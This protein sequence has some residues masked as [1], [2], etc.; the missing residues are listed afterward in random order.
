M[1]IPL[2]HHNTTIFPSPTAFDPN[3][4]INDPKLDRYLFSFSRGPRACIGINLAWAELYNVL[5]S[6]FGHYGDEKGQG[7]SMK[8]WK[9]TI[10]D[11]TTKHDLFVPFPFMESEGVR[12]VLSS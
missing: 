4:W 10:E 3:R 6:V 8:L 5:A 7:P 1:T 11:V 12:I 2:L 9:T